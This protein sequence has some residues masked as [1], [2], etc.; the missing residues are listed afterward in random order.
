MPVRQPQDREWKRDVNIATRATR[1]SLILDII[2]MGQKMGAVLLCVLWVTTTASSST[3]SS[4]SSH[5]THTTQNK[6]EGHGVVMLDVKSNLTR[7]SGPQQPAYFSS[8]RGE[9]ERNDRG[10]LGG[11]TWTRLFVV[12]LSIN[13][14]DCIDATCV[15]FFCFSPPVFCALNHLPSPQGSKDERKKAPFPLFLY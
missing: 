12:V 15:C 10:A 6:R 14:I 7:S 13:C 9:R 11:W 8:E 2:T 5:Q 4:S 1:L 3:T